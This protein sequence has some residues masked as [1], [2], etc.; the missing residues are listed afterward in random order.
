M[1]LHYAIK[2]SKDHAQVMAEWDITLDMSDE[3]LISNFTLNIEGKPLHTQ[4]SDG[5]KA[6]KSAAAAILSNPNA[7]YPVTFVITTNKPD[8][9][10]G[11]D[12][13]RGEK[14]YDDVDFS[15]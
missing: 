4:C 2:V 13:L 8:V 3:E 12:V 9:R 7:D 15:D 6:C 1:S 14:T 10:D 11:S 5:N